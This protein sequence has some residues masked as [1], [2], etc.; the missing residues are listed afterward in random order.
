MFMMN[1]T[2][3]TNKVSPKTPTG[4]HRESLSKVKDARG[5]VMS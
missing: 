3:F 2:S 5:I 4:K 1:E